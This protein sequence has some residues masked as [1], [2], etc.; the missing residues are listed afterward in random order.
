MRLTMGVL[1]MM[2]SWTA[3]WAQ[4]APLQQERVEMAVDSGPIVQRGATR[5]VA[6]S[7]LIEVPGATWIRLFFDEAHL[8]SG[9]EPTLLK[10][11]SLEDGSVQWM[12]AT[13]LQQW[14]NSS[15]YFNGDAVLLEVVSDAQIEPSLIRMSFVMAGP[16]QVERSICGPTDDRVL[17]SDDRTGRIVPIGCTGWMINDPNHC[18]LTAGHCTG[19]TA[20][21]M[22][23]NVPLSTSGGAIQHPPPEDQYAID[24]LSVQSNGGQGIG[25]DWAYLGCFPNPNTSLTPFQAQGVAYDLIL[26][27]PVAGDITIVGYG[28]TDGILAPNEWNQVQKTHTGP[29]TGHAGTSLQYATD[30]TGGNSGSPIFHDQSN[31]AIGIHTHAGCSSGGGENNGTGSEHPD[32]QLALANPQGVCRPL[33]FTFPNGIPEF[34]DPGP[35][36]IRVEVTGQGEGMPMNGTGQVHYDLDDGG[37]TQTVS[38]AVV[39]PNVYDAMIPEVP[40]GTTINLDFSSETTTGDRYF[41][42]HST[43]EQGFDL[44]SADI[45]TASFSDDFETDMGWSV[46][47]DA[48]AGIWERAVPSGDGTR[49]D[50]T[51]D[52]DGSGFCFVT[53]DGSGNT[54]VDG[55]T[56]TLTS[57][58]LDATAGAG[59]ALV[60]Y[61]LWYSSHLGTQDDLFQVEISNDDGG[62]WSALQTIGP[63]GSET[64]GGWTHKAFVISDVLTPTNQ[65]RVRFSAIDTG[66]G[67]VVEAA[68]DGVHILYCGSAIPCP[69]D[70][71][72]DMV[73]DLSDIQL[74]IALWQ[75]TDMSADLNSDGIVDMLD[76]VAIY[77]LLGPCP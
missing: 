61:W 25:D 15:C 75:S 3:V 34:V 58:T 4:L 24:P 27:P 13:H 50:P 46:S 32:L 36:T 16:P 77:D 51:T 8:G 28:T 68:V 60:A 69:A 11:Q 33:L 57:P 20:E 37:G 9:A 18:F 54:D 47:G 10:M 40:C 5:G 7:E 67:S 14:Q 1:C 65:M 31:A 19:S 44:V 63:T 6:F 70:L 21:I 26:P 55:G 35:V 41:A 73:I 29:F 62:S 74:M 76:L 48:T 2:G 43:D 45:S 22:E 42:V 30:T 64:M 38:M 66:T 39:S 56:T 59:D 12:N 53:E 71:N 49:G 72:G 23:F 52:G 17:S